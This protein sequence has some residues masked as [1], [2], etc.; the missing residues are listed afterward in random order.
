M[1]NYTTNILFP[2]SIEI[3][4]INRLFTEEEILFINNIEKKKNKFNSISENDYVLESVE[5]KNIKNEI[6]KGVEHYFYNVIN[7]K[8]DVQ[9]Y[10]TQSWLN[11]TEKNEQHH[12]HNHKNSFLSGSLYIKADPKYD[13]IS[14]V[15]ERN[16]FFSLEPKEFTILN[17]Q[18]WDFPVQTG[19]LIVFPSN[20][21]HKVKEKTNYDLRI[22]LAFNTFIKGKIGS[23]GNK[24]ELVL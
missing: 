3:S 9:I 14:F 16:D 17:S 22:S 4:N 2:T 8:S 21:I 23:S 15:K 18:T 1:E 7:P 19:Q 10:I 12:E 24:T 20:L 5:L 6:V 11:F 13:S